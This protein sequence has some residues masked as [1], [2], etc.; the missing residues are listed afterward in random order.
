MMMSRIEDRRSRIEVEKAKPTSKRRRAR[1][2]CTAF[3][4][5]TENYRFAVIVSTQAHAS[6]GLARRRVRQTG[7][8]LRDAQWRFA[9]HSGAPR[10][11]LNEQSQRGAGSLPWT[12]QNL[13]NSPAMASCS[14][15]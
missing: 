9:A 6:P 11:I 1:R 4:K 2:D 15:F 5:I 14:S 13:Q 3:P 7:K 10:S 12:A 8:A